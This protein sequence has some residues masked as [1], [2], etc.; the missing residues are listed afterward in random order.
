VRIMT[1]LLRNRVM[2]AVVAV[3][4]VLALVSTAAVLALTLGPTGPTMIRVVAAGDMACDPDDPDFLAHSD[5]EGDHC[6]Q[7]DVSQ[8]AAMLDPNLVLGL[9]DYQYEL[10]TRDAYRDVYG[11]S[12]G[13]MRNVTVPVFGNQEYKVHDA[14]TFTEYFGD[15]V[16]DPRGYWSQDIGDWHLVVLNSNCASVEGG[17]GLGSPQ[18]RWLDEDLARTKRQCVLAAWHHPRWSSGIAGPD[19]RTSDLFRTLYDHGVELV[20]SGHEADYERF[21]PLDPA[22][23]PADNGVRQFVVGTGGQ[24]HYEP[25]PED[26]PRRAT[27]AV[28]RSEYVDYHHHGVLELELRPGQWQWRFHAL[29]AEVADQGGARC[30]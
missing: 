29:D 17:C 12:W 27:V 9:G 24:A 23:R 16:R 21:G 13:R 15:R 20:L 14:T 3:E 19:E 11:P 25:A 1:A 18:Q 2:V 5:A 4:L 30:A 10:P 6:R 26:S 8:L 28:P 7:D 22:G